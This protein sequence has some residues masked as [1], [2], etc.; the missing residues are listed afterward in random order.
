MRSSPTHPAAV[1]PQD[2]PQMH[3]PARGCACRPLVLRV[4]LGIVRRAAADVVHEQAAGRTTTRAATRAAA[5]SF[6]TS[7]TRKVSAESSLNRPAGRPAA[8]RHGRRR[9]APSAADQ[10]DV[11]AALGGR[12]AAQRRVLVAACT[13]FRMGRDVGRRV[14]PGGRSHARART[15]AVPPERL[16]RAAPHRLVVPTRGVRIRGAAGRLPLHDRRRLRPEDRADVRRPL[17]R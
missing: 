4:G 9:D 14:R 2:R 17:S 15:R 8:G 1:I 12:Q 16:P 3:R 10:A 6:A 5:A 11:A 7:Q 13:R